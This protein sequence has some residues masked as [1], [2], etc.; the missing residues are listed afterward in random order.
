MQMEVKNI[1]GQ[2]VDTIELSD[3]VFNVALNN[4]VVHQALVMY[5]L[6]KRQGTHSVRVRSQ[7]S[8][9][10]RKPWRQKHTGRARQG[11]TR[12]PQWRH[13]GV[14]FGPHPRDHRREMPRRMRHL[15]LRCVLSEKAR[16]N[17]LILLDLLP[18]NSPRTKSMVEILERL[19]VA[20]S[21]LIVT[22]EPHGNLILSCHNIP[23][24]WTLP[25][26]LLN[27]HEL[28]K[29]H[30]VIMTVEAARRAEELWSKDQS[31]RNKALVSDKP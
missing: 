20:S 8:G 15:A 1:E 6:N 18:L 22:L 7:V 2:S 21:A 28:L 19:A 4:A 30:S 3:K 17:R 16:Q 14:V 25:V 13:G 29:R 27:A 5:Q 11:S 31:P 26:S 10:G 24:V 23:R 12:A 9:G